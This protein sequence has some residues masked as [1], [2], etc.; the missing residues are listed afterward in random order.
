MRGHTQMGERYPPQAHPLLRPQ[1]AGAVPLHLPVRV[2]LELQEV[3]L[4]ALLQAR[5]GLLDV[6]RGYRQGL[7]RIRRVK[8]REHVRGAQGARDELARPRAL[9]QL[10]LLHP[11]R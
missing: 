6:A 3:P 7:Q 9:P 4:V 1:G 11:D 2:Q 10:R 8:Q 5:I